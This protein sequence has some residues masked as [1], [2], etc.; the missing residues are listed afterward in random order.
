MAMQNKILVG[1]EVIFS[2]T[3]IF[4]VSV[5]HSFNSDCLK[6]TVKF[7]K[8]VRVWGRSSS[9][10]LG[11]LQLVERTINAEKYR[12]IQS[13]ALISSIQ[14]LYLIGNFIFQQDDASCKN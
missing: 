12:T 4:E 13:K 5:G 3:S 1:C 9:K 7:S 14:R 10:E 6:R 11:R 8:E 2:N